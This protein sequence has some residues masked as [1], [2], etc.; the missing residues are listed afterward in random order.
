MEITKKLT[1]RE[2]VVEI[3]DHTS[4]KGGRQYEEALNRTM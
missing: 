3:L 1:K 2:M 4:L